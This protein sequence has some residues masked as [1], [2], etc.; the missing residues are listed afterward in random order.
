MSNPENS[1]LIQFIYASTRSNR[2]ALCSKNA[3][4]THTLIHQ[5]D[6]EHMSQPSLLKLS[7]LNLP[8]LLFHTE[9]GTFKNRWKNRRPQIDK[10]LSKLATLPR[11]IQAKD[12]I[13]GKSEDTKGSHSFYD[14]N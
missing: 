14:A 7:F 11:S 5:E 3:F 9:R 6:A 8:T 10:N 12:F 13:T 1:N 2:V 4:I